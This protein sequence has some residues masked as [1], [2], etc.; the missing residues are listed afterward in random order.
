MRQPVLLD[1]YPGRFREADLRALD[2][3]VVCSS[4]TYV[5]TPEE[6]TRLAKQQRDRV[7]RQLWITVVSI[8]VTVIGISNAMLM[9]VTER[10]REIGTMK[11]LGALDRFILRLFLLEAGIQGLAGAFVGAFGGAMAALAVMALRLGWAA[12]PALS[13]S[14]VLQ[15]LSESTLVGFGLSLLGVL[16]PA[17]IASRMQP[18]DAM[19]AEY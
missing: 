7:A 6:Q 19:R 3:R 4:L 2:Q 16:Y 11:C 1:Y 13:G 14:G 15:G 18:V 10:I 5:A 9:S 8:L 17:W 12:L